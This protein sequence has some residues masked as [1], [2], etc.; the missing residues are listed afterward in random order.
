MK[1]PDA[2]PR[3][4]GPF[5]KYPR[6]IE[7]E[8]GRC[9]KVCSNCGLSQKRKIENPGPSPLEAPSDQDDLLEYLQS[10]G[11]EGHK[12]EV[13]V[14]AIREAYAKKYAE[15]CCPSQTCLCFVTFLMNSESE[16][17]GV[18]ELA[19]IQDDAER[20]K[21]LRRVKPRKKL[22]KAKKEDDMETDEDEDGEEDEDDE[23]DDPDTLVLD[24]PSPKKRRLET[25]PV[26]PELEKPYL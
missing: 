21:K 11:L 5:G 9:L 4:Y 10:E 1:D 19:I 13:V 25:E 23:E 17:K 20:L 15:V 14:E 7:V 2:C 12:G 16:A 3:C 18:L 6:Y 8:K 22:K 24:Q 26:L